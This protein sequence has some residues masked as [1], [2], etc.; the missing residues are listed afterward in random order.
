[1]ET[2]IS[3]FSIPVALSALAALLLIARTKAANALGWL[4]LAGMWIN[5]FLAIKLL[6]PVF[7]DNGPEKVQMLAA[8]LSLDGPAALFILLTSLVSATVLSHARLFFRRARERNEELDDSALITY[9]LFSLLFH[10]SMVAVFLCDNLGYLWISIEATTLMSAALV[11]FNRDKHALE[12]AW[13]YLII[14]SVGIAFALFGT[15]CFYISSKYG[16]VPGGSLSLSQLAEVAPHLEPTY[17][18]LAFILCFLGY[19]TKAGLFPLHSWLPDAYSEAPAPASAMIAGALLNCALFAIFRIYQVAY[20]LDNHA[21]YQELVLWSGTITVVAA[22]I[23]LVRQH[24]IKRL[25]GYSSIENAGLLLVAIGLNSTPIFL[26]HAVNHSIAKVALF[27]LSGDIIQHAGSKELSQIKGIWTSMPVRSTL[28]AGAAIAVTGAPPF[29]AFISEWLLL[30][31]C[32]S[33]G[34]WFQ[35]V[36]LVLAISLAFIMV[37]FHTGRILGGGAPKEK[38]TEPEHAGFNGIVPG[39]LLIAALALG[40]ATGPLVLEW[41]Q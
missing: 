37:A 12:A 41:L 10:V 18:R 23:F 27:L 20:C 13:K 38:A 28:F 7:V 14:C 2:I 9:Y 40:I 33:Q 17:V 36:L 30:T 39:A 34:R 19:G 15:V 32:V 6:A 1:M 29:G 4:V 21:F 26:L 8:G 35:A 11:Y 5:L 22:S 24:G 16:A 3:L 25:W 31:G